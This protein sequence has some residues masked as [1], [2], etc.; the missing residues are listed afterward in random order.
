VSDYKGLSRARWEC[1][2]HVVFIAKYHKDGEL[3]KRL[4]EVF[5]TIAP[6][7]LR[8]PTSGHSRHACGSAPRSDANPSLSLAVH[9]HHG[10]LAKRGSRI[11][12]ISASHSSRR[13][14]A[15]VVWFAGHDR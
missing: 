11:A 15:S 8:C 3:R 14:A 10:L 4:G 5:R 9:L 7:A 2:Y 13:T 12:P 6:P 1:K